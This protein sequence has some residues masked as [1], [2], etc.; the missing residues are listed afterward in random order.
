MQLK[1]RQ[2]KSPRTIEKKTMLR[3]SRFNTAIRCVLAR[4][5]R[6]CC[7]NCS[8]QA[9]RPPKMLFGEKSGTSQS[10]WR[11]FELTPKWSVSAANAS[12]PM[13]EAIDDAKTVNETIGRWPHTVA[14]G[15]WR[16]VARGQRIGGV[17]NLSN[18]SWCSAQE[19]GDRKVWRLWRKLRP[20]TLS[21]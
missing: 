3:T 12:Q 6:K 7:Q 14:A 4:W 17:W 9:T 20:F 2:P 13:R 15:K 8:K 5:A 21:Y 19:N 16:D 18:R 11:L 1:R 10:N